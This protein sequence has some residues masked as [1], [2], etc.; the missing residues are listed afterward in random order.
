MIDLQAILTAHA[1]LAAV[2]IRYASVD[3]ASLGAGANQT[4]VAA[5]AGKKIRVLAWSISCATTASVKLTSGA[6]GATI[7]ATSQVNATVPNV[8]PYSP[9]GWCETAAGQAL[10]VNNPTAGAI[11][12]GLQVAYV[13]VG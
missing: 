9:V 13:E 2:S 5:V 3:V 1:D 10:V 12:F 6:G 4:V 8:Y 11:G 7:F